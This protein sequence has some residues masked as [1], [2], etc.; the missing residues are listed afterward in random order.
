MSAVN[1]CEVLSKIEDRGW[2]EDP[3]ALRRF[4]M[5]IRSLEILPFGASEA[6]VAAALRRPTRQLLSLG[7]R[8][9]LATA[10]THKLPVLT[11]E[12]SWGD[13]E[14]GVVVELIR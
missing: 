4:R 6:R 2:P 3:E 7:D 5:V 10:R 14:L 12:R 9:C 1:L 13:L 11:A 8:C